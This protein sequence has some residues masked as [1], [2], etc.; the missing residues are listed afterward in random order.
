V[1]AVHELHRSSPAELKAR[2]DAERRGVPFLMLRD[3]D[4]RQRIIGLDRAR[5]RLSI[6]RQASSDVALTWD[7]EVSRAHAEIER[8][9]EVWTLVDDGRSRNGSFVNGRRMHGR[10]P[11][12]TGDVVR[13]GHTCLTYVAPERGPEH[14]TAVAASDLAPPVS[15]AQRRVLVALC[16]PL[17]A[18]P[19]ATPPS[20]R[21][22]ARELFL[23]VE[24]VKD[25]LHAL[26]TAFGLGDVPQHQ[27]RATL[28]RLAL[29]RGAVSE[30]E[31]LETPRQ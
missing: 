26:F 10:R 23:S 14:S 9:G 2:R 11:L 31:L 8:I 22:L 1:D 30:R 21:D 25:H 17:A 29:E 12:R 27:K 13:V 7:D 18:G 3:G 15:A 19:F 6:G 5:S 4:G 28:A 16:R 20:N 24:T